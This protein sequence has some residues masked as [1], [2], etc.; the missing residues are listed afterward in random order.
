MKDKSK[1]FKEIRSWV[2]I[3]LGAF[4]L[5]FFIN[6]EVLAKVVVEH[7]SMENTLFAN[8]QLLVNEFSYHFTQPKKGDIIIFFPEEEKGNIIVRFDRYLDGIK[9]MFT[10]KSEH[11]RYVKRVIGVEGDVIEI[12]DGYVF[13]NDEKIDEPY[14]NGLTEPK[15]YELPCTVGKDE[16]FVMGDHRTVSEDSRAFGPISLDQVIGRA[17]YRV[18]PFGEM[19]K[20]Q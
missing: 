13:V 9:E 18:Y 19:G 16:L 6:S 8:Q 7:G 1:L 20:I 2:L 3:I 17:F 14:T 11:A 4:I 15:G 12:K 5:A 10:K